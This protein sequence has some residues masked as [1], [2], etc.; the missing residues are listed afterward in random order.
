M[1]TEG[2]SIRKQEG[3]DNTGLIE[4]RAPESVLFL[5]TNNAYSY[6]YSESNDNN[7]NHYI[8]ENPGKHILMNTVI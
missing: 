5:M 7:G 8:N 1:F 3:F 6:N 2:G 4:M